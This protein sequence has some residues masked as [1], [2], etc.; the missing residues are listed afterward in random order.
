[1][2]KVSDK[3]SSTLACSFY[4]DENSSMHRLSCDCQEIFYVL[5]TVGLIPQSPS[6][7]VTG[8]PLSPIAK[9]ASTVTALLARQPQTPVSGTR[10]FVQC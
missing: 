8:S 7:Q 1:M 4:K 9:S 2:F 5:I 6:A 3:M 10:I